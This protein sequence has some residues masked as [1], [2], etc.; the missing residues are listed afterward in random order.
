MNRRLLGVVVCGALGLAG[1]GSAKT[2]PAASGPDAAQGASTSAALAP[3][4]PAVQVP[5]DAPPDRVL[6]T[7]LDALKNGDTATKASLLTQKALTETTRHEFEVNPQSAPN[8]QFQVHP[9]EFLPDNPNGAHV[10]SVWTETYEDGQI[11]YDVVWVLRR[12]EEGWRIAGMAI[13]LIPGR[14]AAFLNF[15]DPADMEAKY[16]EAIAAQQALQAPA[17]ETAAKPQAPAIQANPIER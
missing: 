1:C 10:T 16:K 11:T 6:A 9:P 4:K 5:A 7:F 12:E 14:P 3:M 17:A 8:A 2:D 15:E 13:E